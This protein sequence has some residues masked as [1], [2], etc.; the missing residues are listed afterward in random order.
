MDKLFELLGLGTPFLYA[1]GTYAFFHWLD[2]SASDEAKDEL[3]R[4]V[5]VRNYETKT[6]SGGVVQIFDRIYTYPLF[7]WQAFLRSALITLAFSVIYIYEFDVSLEQDGVFFGGSSFLANVAS[8]YVS[9]FIIRKWLIAAA[10]RPIAALLLSS[11]V[12]L[13]VIALSAVLRVLGIAVAETFAGLEI[14]RAILFTLIFLLPPIG[15]SLTRIFE[16]EFL[17]VPAMIVFAWL[18]LFGISLL[19]IRLINILTTTVGKMQW[20]L[21]GGQ[22]HPLIA[23]GYVASVIVFVTAVALKFLLGAA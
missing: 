8:D 21:K 14:S 7:A 11:I 16:P 15:D 19:I 23:V 6:I 4:L 3:A 5:R 2:V 17:L 18:P 20:F 1:A 22:D 13:F 9:L 10:Q 12:W